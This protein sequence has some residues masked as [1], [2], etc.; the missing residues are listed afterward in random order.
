VVAGCRLENHALDVSKIVLKGKKIPKW[1][2][3]NDKCIIK[4]W[5]AGNM[6]QNSST[7]IVQSV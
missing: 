2:D 3:I 6:H 4:L 5:N 1:G 7:T